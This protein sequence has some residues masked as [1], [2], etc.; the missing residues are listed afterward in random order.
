MTFVAR[1]NN[2]QSYNRIFQEL[3]NPLLITLSTLSQDAETPSRKRPRLTIDM[4]LDNIK[5]HSVL[6]DPTKEDKVEAQTLRRAIVQRLF[7]VANGPD[8]RESNRKWMVAVWKAEMAEVIGQ[9][10][11]SDL[12]GS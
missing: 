6:E 8:T 7:E 9:K 4:P 3:Y 5:A 2:R 1:T 11:T 12:D 10:A